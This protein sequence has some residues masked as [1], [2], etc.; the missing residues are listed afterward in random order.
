VKIKQ[1]FHLNL[2]INKNTHKNS[3][4]TKQLSYNNSKA[5]HPTPPP[6]TLHAKTNISKPTL[7][8]P[9]NLMRFHTQAA[10]DCSCPIVKNNRYILTSDVENKTQQSE[11][12]K[13]PLFMEN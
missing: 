10:S 5:S 13:T 12:E 6:E 1:E 11:Q 7:K 9:P 4:T 8:P 3:S 2:S